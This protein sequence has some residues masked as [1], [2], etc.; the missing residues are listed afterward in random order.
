[1][2]NTTTGESLL[3]EI[4]V[5]VSISVSNSIPECKQFTPKMCANGIKIKRKKDCYLI[6]HFYQLILIHA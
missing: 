1:M 6:A 4:A 3:K 2:F 5:Y